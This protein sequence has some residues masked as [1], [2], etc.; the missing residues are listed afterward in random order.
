MYASNYF[1][2]PDVDGVIVHIV[3]AQYAVMHV[4]R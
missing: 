2:F 4:L 1:P 3:T